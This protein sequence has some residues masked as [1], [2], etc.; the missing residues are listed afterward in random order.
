VW[1]LEPG[2]TLDLGALPYAS[3]DVRW[4]RIPVDSD[5]GILQ[6]GIRQ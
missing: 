1:P 2:A 5:V 6:A 3:L 4:V